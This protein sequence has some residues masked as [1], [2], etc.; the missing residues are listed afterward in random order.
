MDERPRDDAIPADA[1][2]D[3]IIDALR[4]VIQGIADTF[5]PWC[6]VVLHDYRQ[7]AHSVV[8]I[9]G[10]VTNRHVGGAMSEIGLSM[11]ARGDGAVNDL[12]Y[13]TRTPHGKVIKSSTMPLRDGRGHVF[14]AICINL[15]IMPLRQ[16][17][18]LVDQLVG[19]EARQVAT[20]TFT[21][22][23][24]EVV[25]AMVAAEEARLAKPAATLTP[26][27]RIE[28]VGALDARGVF[29]VRNAVPRVAAKLGV[30]RSGL[31][32]TLTRSRATRET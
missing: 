5:G 25:D 20:T 21:D 16:V 24:D 8:A 17:S 31:Y 22:D 2:Q 10:S 18:S 6:E 1:S 9:A 30:S 23:F 27:E 26:E 19:A 11:L 15:D 14:A 12:N 3:A 4:P 7:P 29:S 32:A 28:L 13:V